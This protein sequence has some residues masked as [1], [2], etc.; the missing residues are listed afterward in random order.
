[1]TPEDMASMEK[2]LRQ[3]LDLIEVRENMARRGETRGKLALAIGILLMV[4]A[5]LVYFGARA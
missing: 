1:M 4:V 2:R 3:Q 5:V